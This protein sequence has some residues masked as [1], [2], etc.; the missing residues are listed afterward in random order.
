MK[1][2]QHALALS[3]VVALAACGGGGDD[4]APASATPLALANYG[5]VSAVAVESV[6]G[7]DALG[8]LL[9]QASQ[10]GGSALTI[11]E[12][13]SGD[14]LV[15]SRLAI[16][17]VTQR[18]TIKA[19]AAAVSQVTE[20][21]VG[22]GSLNVIVDDADNNER[23][24]AGDIV[25][26][27]ANNCVAEIGQSAVNG[28]LSI[29]INSISLSNIGDVIAA[30]LSLTVS[31]LSSGGASLNGAIDASVDAQSLTLRYRNL[32]AVS[33][34]AR[35]TFDFTRRENLADG[36]VTVNGNLVIN[37]SSYLLSTP[38]ILTPGAIAFS[39]G[40]L[41][42]ADRSGGY[43]DVVMSSTG[44]TANLYLPG[45]TVVDASTLVSWSG[46]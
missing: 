37:G 18:S 5:N 27:N 22:G 1:L 26:I 40:T 11:N 39:N 16:R 10:S 17:Q 4:A 38:A 7:G 3:A 44:Y 32:A 23:E 45:D 41:R 2:S 12:L 33:G 25:T 42:V 19:R 36:A 46:R 13:G 8:S 20:A 14:A 34:E 21:C 28:Q 31:N 15:I 35:L 6:G 30:S 9:P 29:R 43:T 24:S